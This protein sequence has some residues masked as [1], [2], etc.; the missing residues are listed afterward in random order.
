MRIS[1]RVLISFRSDL[2]LPCC[3]RFSGL[4]LMFFIPFTAFYIWQIV[5]FIMGIQR[6]RVLYNFYTHLLKIP[7]VRRLPP[8]VIASIDSG[9]G[10]V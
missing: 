10:G 8:Y 5:S 3:S 7:D 4:T 2:N 1:V 9:D 6:L